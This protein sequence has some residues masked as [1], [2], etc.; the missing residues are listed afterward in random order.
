MAFDF[1]VLD[2]S[3][4]NQDNHAVF[5]STHGKAG[6]GILYQCFDSWDCYAGMSGSGEG[7]S[8]SIEQFRVSLNFLEE[9]L[10]LWGGAERGIV[11]L[12]H[13]YEFIE[14]VKVYLEEKQ[15]STL[16]VIFA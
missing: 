2:A 5:A 16:A 10:S 14:E 1:L 13:H 4:E 9:F 15:P 6:A 7:R 3:D 8:F 11:H 12:A